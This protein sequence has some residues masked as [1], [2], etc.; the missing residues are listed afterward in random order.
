MGEKN[1]KKQLLFVEKR[2]EIR[3][4]FANPPECHILAS[5][6]MW[7]AKNCLKNSRRSKKSPI[8]DKKCSC[9]VMLSSGST[10]IWLQPELPGLYIFYQILVIFGFFLNFLRNFWQTT[11]G[12]SPKCDILE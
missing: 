11:S 1:I 10:E 12:S 7:F 6:Q 3:H 5:Y 2:E 4:V 8:V 9:L